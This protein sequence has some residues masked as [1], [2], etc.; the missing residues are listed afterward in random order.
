MEEQLSIQE[1]AKRY[2]EVSKEVKDF[3]EGR[4]KMYSDVSQT[5][6]HLFPELKESEGERVRK[7]ITLCLEE[8]V[9]S[10]IIR[11]YEK[12]DVI[13]WLEKQGQK[14]KLIKELGLY[15]VK[16]TQ[17]TLEKHINSISNKDDE[18]LRKTTISFLKDFVDKGYENAVECIEWLENQNSDTNKEYWRGYCE[19]RQEILDK[20]SELKKSCVYP[21]YSQS[22]LATK[23]D[24]QN[25]ASPADKIE[26][27]FHEG[28]IIKPKDGGHEPWQIIQVDMLDRKYRFK[29]GYVVHFSQEDDY[30]LVEQKPDW[31]EEDEYMLN[32]TIQHLKQLIEID[33]AKYCACNVQYY[34]R[35]IDW[36]IHLKDRVHP[37]QRQEWS[38]EDEKIYQSIMDDTVQENQLND[39]QTNWLAEL[40]SRN[41]VGTQSTWK[42][43][44]EQL[45]QLGWIAKQNKNNMI[46]K[47][48]MTLLNDLKKL[49]EE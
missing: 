9:H 42:P 2:D 19:G 45:R 34:Q 12:D 30:E 32:E 43:S 37:Q 22:T 48:L 35:D 21:V 3:F 46:G 38:K 4:Q 36:L 13:A 39:K 6:E 27:K 26:P 47:E 7:I 11:D 29:D 25:C 10:D 1:K 18:R 15:K 33:K 14:D 20:Y 44:D 49:R 16:Y 40:K 31:S 5:L 8:C 23:V 41:F 24:N 17:E 28:D